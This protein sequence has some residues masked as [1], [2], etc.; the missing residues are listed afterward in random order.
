M[1]QLPPGVMSLPQEE[2]RCVLTAVYNRFIAL[3]NYD[4]S[5]LPVLRSSIVLLKPSMPS[6]K[7][8]EEDYGLSK[9]TCQKVQVHVVEG[10]HLTM[11]ND[12]KVATILNDETTEISKSVKENGVIISKINLRNC[13][14]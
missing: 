3:Q 9:I 12:N 4:S 8:T 13:S 5:K 10:N 1:K 7:F 11:L 2:V 6:I 14:A